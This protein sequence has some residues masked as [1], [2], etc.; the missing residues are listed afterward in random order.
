MLHAVLYHSSETL[1]IEEVA[2]QAGINEDQEQR[3][4]LLDIRGELQRKW[5]ANK[6]A[7]LFKFT[8]YQLRHVPWPLQAALF[9]KA[10][11]GVIEE[12]IHAVGD[13]L[14]TVSHLAEDAYFK[15]ADALIAFGHKTAGL[16][17]AVGEKTAD[18]AGKTFD[19]AVAA[20]E[21]TVDLAVAAGEKTVDIATT[22]AEKTAVAA[23]L[24]GEKSVEAANIVGN[25]TAE[26]YAKLG[27][28]TA[29]A[30]LVAKDAAH[31]IKDKTY[32]A[33]ALFGHKTADIASVVAPLAADIAAEAKSRLI[34]LTD[35]IVYS[36]TKAYA[37]A[38]MEF[39]RRRRMTD[40]D[41]QYAI[42]NALACSSVI[43]GIGYE[44]YRQSNCNFTYSF[45]LLEELERKWRQV[46]NNSAVAFANAK[47]ASLLVKGKFFPIAELT[48]AAPVTTVPTTPLEKTLQAESLRAQTAFSPAL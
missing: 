17:S 7:Q 20:G 2:I 38:L 8:P 30:R 40:F 44:F 1:K 32:E 45:I 28:K 27:D 46:P 21:K 47:K 15:T 5:V 11:P 29:E 36:T 48:K 19:Y 26:A 4:R 16:A 23:S 42:L 35:E 18:L 9:V 3:R 41:E 6:T 24:V 31:L 39:E 22:A 13:A 25:K 43:K 37:H 12:S 10:A 14:H 34:H 33:A